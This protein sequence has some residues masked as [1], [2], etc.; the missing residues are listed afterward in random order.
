MPV[1]LVV[2]LSREKLPT[3]DEWQQ[4]ID[5][6]GLDLKLDHAD[7][8]THTGYWPANLNGKQCGFE[9][10]FQEAE[11]VGG[12]DPPPVPRRGWWARLFGIPRVSKPQQPDEVGQ[13]QEVIGERDHTV[14]FRTHSSLDELEAASLAGAVL[15]QM[16]DGVFFDPQSGEHA[17][18]EGAFRRL[19]DQELAERERK[20]QVAMKKWSGTTTR[21][22]PQCDAPCPE[23]RPSCFVC[24]YEI[25]RA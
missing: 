21:R 7:T 18:G 15:A 20:M 14:V 22:C 5:G 16:T 10:F 25:G 23:Y 2:F 19:H 13:L 1:E 12:P 11:P 3:R 9:Y 17:I 8:A 4:A 24:N 6:A